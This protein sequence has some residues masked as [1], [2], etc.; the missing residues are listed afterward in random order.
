LWMLW[1]R[2]LEEED[3]L[4]KAFGKEWEEWHAKTAR[5]VPGIF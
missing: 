5:F 2:T 4:R 1:K 3:M